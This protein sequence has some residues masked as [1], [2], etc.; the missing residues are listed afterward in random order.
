MCA[1]VYAR[2]RERKEG[3][4]KV[5]YVDEEECTHISVISFNLTSFSGN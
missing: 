5:R 2:V 4:R 3:R 1:R